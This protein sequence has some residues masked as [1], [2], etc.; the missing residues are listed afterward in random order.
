MLLTI[1]SRPGESLGTQRTFFSTVRQDFDICQ[2]L[3]NTTEKR[4]TYILWLR[5]R[6][7]RTQ[8][9][10]G[11]GSAGSSS[12]LPHA[13]LRSLRLPRSR[14][15]P[16]R[17]RSLALLPLDSDALIEALLTEHC[18]WWDESMWT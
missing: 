15:L 11:A 1:R 12:R 18:S 13:L 2:V 14:K 6:R 5:R 8:G 16:T 3:T 17:W 9:Q 7:M 4:G 10:R